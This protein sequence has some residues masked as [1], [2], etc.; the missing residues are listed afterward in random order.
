MDDGKQCL[1]YRNG[2]LSV[3][4]KNGY[5][6]VSVSVSVSVFQLPLLKGGPGASL[7]LKRLILT[8]YEAATNTLRGCYEYLERPLLRP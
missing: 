6:S 2:C 8:P 4:V 7:Y 1:K 3:P 5:L